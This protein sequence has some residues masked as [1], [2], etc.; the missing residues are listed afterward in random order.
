M[1]AGLKGTTLKRIVERARERPTDDW[2]HI[3]VE[4]LLEIERESSTINGIDA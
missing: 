1:N 4:V 2:Y 3:V